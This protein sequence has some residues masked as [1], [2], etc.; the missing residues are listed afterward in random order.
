VLSPFRTEWGWGRVSVEMVGIGFRD[1]PGAHPGLRPGAFGELYMNFGLPAVLVGGA[2]L[3]YACVRLHAATKHAVAMYP[4]FHA[5]LVLLAAFTTLGAM[6]H[7][8]NT[9]TFFS[10]YVSVAVLV[11]LRMCKSVLRASAT[12]P[13]PARTVAPAS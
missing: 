7:F 12:A 8:Y 3:G 10:V 4:P 6:F 1:T 11:F 9:A 5:K 13:A 2:L